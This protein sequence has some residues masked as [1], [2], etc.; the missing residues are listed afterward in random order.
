MIITIIL[1]CSVQNVIGN[2]GDKIWTKEYLVDPVGDSRQ[3]SYHETEPVCH[4][5]HQSP[6]TN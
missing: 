5:S 4:K 3:V 1:L 2:M 6:F